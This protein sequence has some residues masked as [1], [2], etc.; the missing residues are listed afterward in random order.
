MPIEISD[1]T[2]LQAI[3]SDLTGEYVLINDIDASGTSSWNSGAGFDP[4]GAL[5][6]PFTGSLNGGGFVISD[7]YIN[8]PAENLVAL[9]CRPETAIAPGICDFYLRDVSIVGQQYVG[10]IGGATFS[11]TTAGIRRVGCSGSVT[12]TSNS[13]TAFIAGFIGANDNGTFEDCYARVAVT[14]S[15]NGGRVG[16]F[17][18]D[19]R[20]AVNRC[21][22][23]GTVTGSG[24]ST[25]GF[26]GRNSVAPVD[27][28]WDTE[29]SGR[30][31]S[32]GGTG[33]TTAE[34]QD[35][36]TYDPE[37]DIV[38]ES[39]HDGQFATAVWFIDDGVDYPKLWFEYE[40]SGTTYAGSV[41]FG[42]TADL[43]MSYALT[44]GRSAAFG[45]DADQVMSA[46]AAV[47]A[48]IA[49]GAQGADAYSYALTFDGTNLFA[50][51]AALTAA[52]GAQIIATVGLDSQLTLDISRTNAIVGSID[53]AIESGFT[54]AAQAFINGSVLLA[55][56]QAIQAG[57]M[58]LVDA[59]IEAGAIIDVDLDGGLS[60][61]AAVAMS[62]MTALTMNR[63]VQIPLS[64][65]FD[66]DAA[67]TASH[68]LTVGGDI[69]LA[70]EAVLNT[71][72]GIYVDAAM[73]LGIELDLETARRLI[74]TS[75]TTPLSRMT[76][77]VAE[78]RIVRVPAEER[79]V[80]V[81]IDP[82]LIK[83]SNG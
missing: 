72:A 55:G 68:E 38:L 81:R 79:I 50:A 64:L 49:L 54:I 4:I 22:S 77:V 71:V 3:N 45:F 37:W 62:F 33:K 41:G 31:T 17:S 83:P 23:T 57:L 11:G 13:T 35:I 16:G 25:G 8:R 66:A 12:G 52:A 32:G 74:T 51:T 19:T 47:Q 63:E 18:G 78:R 26:A 42:A 58:A 1:A 61:E 53:L 10:A 27:C 34:M 69:G 70:A 6:S 40:E 82:R 5:S 30:A 80:I 75:V 56:Q 36:D 73:S 46:A 20:S 65:L 76:K 60:V 2:E 44:A 24:G 43:S 59:A 9:F 15:N 21:Y 48:A 39:A 14:A 28:F 29:S 67:A 7:L